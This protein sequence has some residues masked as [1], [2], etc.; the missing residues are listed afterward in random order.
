MQNTY[1]IYLT[2][3]TAYAIFCLGNML[4]C[5]GLAALIYWSKSYYRHDHK[6]DTKDFVD[7]EDKEE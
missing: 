1:D 3:A 4:F 5:F 7:D 2:Y 6:Y